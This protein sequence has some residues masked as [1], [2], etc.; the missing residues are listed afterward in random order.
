MNMKVVKGK[1]VFTPKEMYCGYLLAIHHK[2]FTTDYINIWECE[3][4]EKMEELSKDKSV[5]DVAV[6]GKFNIDYRK[7][8]EDENK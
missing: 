8:I 2:D 1:W 4:D 7:E 3:I 5:I 6:Y